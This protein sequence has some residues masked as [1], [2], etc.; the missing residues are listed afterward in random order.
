MV[1]DILIG[2]LVLGLELNARYI[3]NSVK[4][5]RSIYDIGVKHFF[6]PSLLEKKDIYLSLSIGNFTLF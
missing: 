1:G 3:L 5:R 4:V 6:G 2:I